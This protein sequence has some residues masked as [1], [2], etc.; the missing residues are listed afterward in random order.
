MNI[1][2]C[3]EN[4]GTGGVE[5]VVF[6]QAIAL[7][8]QGNQIYLLSGGGEYQVKMEENGI[9]WIPFDFKVENTFPIQ[10]VDKMVALVQEKKINQIYVHKIIC[11]PLMLMVCNK[12]KIPYVVYVH[13]ELPQ[14]YEWFM[15]NFNIYD[16]SM[17]LF[18]QNA[19]KIICISEN[20]KKYSQKYLEIADDKYLIIKNSV[21]FDIYKC[22]NKI[23]KELPE[24]FAI[25]SRIAHEKFTS[26]KNAIELF[27]AYSD[28]T[29]FKTK[30]T[31]IGDGDKKEE[32]LSLIE[33]KKEKYQIEYKGAT[34]DVVR[35]MNENDVI[36][37]L[38]RCALE[39]MAI[40]RIVVLSGYENLKGI[41]KPENIDLALEDNLSGNN[42]GTVTLET[43]VEQLLNLSQNEIERITEENYK[44]IVEKTDIKHNLY[45]IP[46]DITKNEIDYQD[47]YTK[48]N[49]MSEKI[50]S[51]KQENNEIWKDRQYF[52][53]QLD[54]KNKENEDLE[55]TNTKLIEEK[56][57]IEKENK[58]TVEENKKLHEELIRIKNRK[59]YKIMDKV[60]KLTKFKF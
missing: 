46:E 33:T 50:N 4:L 40:K 51:L 14:T 25:V 56:E 11:I 60:T 22:T 36:L 30:L 21:N 20:A 47:M 10:D 58:K 12:A 35:V 54:N 13:D 1:L 59:I 23:E 43:Q 57:K 7:K 32:L 44:K 6:N 37:G 15:N 2:I 53:E 49:K 39:A 27:C 29:Q 19:Y 5:T 48:I 55:N 34:N 18:F 28:K 41:L 45:K 24:N 52:K 17:K 42:L 26:V 3:T 8:E 31:I 16:L 38:N 9:Q